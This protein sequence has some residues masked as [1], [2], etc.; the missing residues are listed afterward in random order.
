M[1]VIIFLSKFQKDDECIGLFLTL[2]LGESYVW[3]RHSGCISR[4]RE[5]GVRVISNEGALSVVSFH[6]LV[7]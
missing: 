6:V 7:P 2:W 3:W 5:E 4:R 1:L